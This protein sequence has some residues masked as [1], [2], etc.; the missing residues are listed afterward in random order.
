[1]ETFILAGLLGLG[2][3]MASG[4]RAFMPLLMVGLADRFGFAG[5]ELGEGFAWLSSDV[6]LGALTVAMIAE[7]V[8]DK[9]PV[10]DNAMDAV[11]IVAR[12][13][14]GAFAAMAAFSSADPAVPAL[15][16]IVA[17]PAAG[18][19]QLLKG[20]TRVASTASTTGLGNPIVS[21]F[22]DVAAVVGVVLAFLAPLL[23]PLFAAIVLFM[24]WRAFRFFRAR[25]A[26]RHG[27]AFR[28]PKI[29]QP[30]VMRDPTP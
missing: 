7:F 4:F 19:V 15:I 23:V 18:A 13:A 8:A 3:A 1:M 6:A 14:I 9:V 21:L 26:R 16:A 29:F 30:K 27:I 10:V 5:I 11:G 28:G 17:A 25:L 20:A 2:V 22:E 24:A 12:P